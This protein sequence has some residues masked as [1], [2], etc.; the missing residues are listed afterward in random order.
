MSTAG[1]LAALWK[2]FRGFLVAIGRWLLTFARRHGLTRLVGYMLGKVDDF[3]RRWKRAKTDRRRRW[4]RGRIRRWTRAAAW[5]T[6]HAHELH[7]DALEQ[8]EK[9]AERIP[10]TAPAERKAA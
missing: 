3:G 8:W 1:I 7:A 9:L 5:L 2:I 10:M 6:D 4:L